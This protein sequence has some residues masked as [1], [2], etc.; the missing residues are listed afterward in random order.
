MGWDGWR[1]NIG[2]ERDS[3]Q[4][5]LSVCLAIC[6]SHDANILVPLP[7][8]HAFLNLSPTTDTSRRGGSIAGEGSPL[9][10]SWHPSKKALNK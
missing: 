4:V 7:V 6:P 3:E 9:E 8:L 1:E 2:G 5:C 10:W